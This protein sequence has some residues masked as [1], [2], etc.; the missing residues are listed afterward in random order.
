MNCYIYRS[1]KKV[2]SYL[3]LPEKNNFSELPEELLKL[4]GHPE[5]AFQFDLSSKKQLASID[6]Q[7]V[8]Q[9]LQEQGFYLQ[10]PPPEI[11]NR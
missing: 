2:G 7:T 6:S 4:F 10:I 11:R 5:F 3:Y 1:R 8:I 9:H